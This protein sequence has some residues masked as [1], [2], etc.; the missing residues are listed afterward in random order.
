[1]IVDRYII[2]FGGGSMVVPKDIH[3]HDHPTIGQYGWAERRGKKRCEMNVSKI[4]VLHFYGNFN[5]KMLFETR[6]ALGISAFETGPN[7]REKFSRV[8]FAVGWHCIE[9]LTVLA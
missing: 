3:H 7:L 2:Q 5:G 6:G 9:R 4:G 8:V 1:M